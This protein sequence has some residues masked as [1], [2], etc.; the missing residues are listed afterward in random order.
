[1]PI[2]KNK[3]T[4]V[5]ET[6]CYTGHLLLESTPT[7]LPQSGTNGALLLGYH[8]QDKA[9]TLTFSCCLTTSTSEWMDSSLSPGSPHTAQTCIKGLVGLVKLVR[10]FYC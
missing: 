1:M 9:V 8:L 2:L 5:L 6:S 4:P 3:S 7:L 10:L